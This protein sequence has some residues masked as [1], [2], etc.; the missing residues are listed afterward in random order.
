MKMK[1]YTNFFMGNES[2]K[3]SIEEKFSPNSAL[4]LPSK[5]KKCFS[6]R[7]SPNTQV[8]EF[9]PVKCHYSGAHM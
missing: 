6:S 3:S 7:F 8:M 9:K 4:L 5:R 1:N 2:R